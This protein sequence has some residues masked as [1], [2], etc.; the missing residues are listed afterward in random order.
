MEPNIQVNISVRSSA[1]L[2]E[3]L[4]RCFLVLLWLCVFFSLVLVTFLEFIILPGFL[5]NLASFGPDAPIFLIEKTHR[6]S[7]F[8]IY[9]L[10]SLFV[11]IYF[12]L[13][14]KRSVSFFV[15]FTILFLEIIAGMLTV[16]MPMFTI[17]STIAH[18]SSVI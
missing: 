5:K 11:A 2:S 18:I 6:L 10:A 13:Q 9:P 16:G 17:Y 8:A 3:P 15:A 14:S 7:F 4:F 12:S 1:K